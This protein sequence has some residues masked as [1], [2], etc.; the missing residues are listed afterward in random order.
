MSNDDTRQALAAFNAAAEEYRTILDEHQE[1]ERELDEANKAV[2]SLEKKAAQAKACLQ[3]LKRE[4]DIMVGLWEKAK[5]ERDEAIKMFD[6]ET[7][8]TMHQPDV[9]DLLM[10]SDDEDD[11]E[12]KMQGTMIGDNIKISK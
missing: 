9:I 3:N 10:S 7:A 6:N 12:E 8:A 11:V 4:R 2:S 1:S 5:T